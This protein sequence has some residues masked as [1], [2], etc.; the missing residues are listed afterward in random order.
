[1]RRVLGIALFVIGCTASAQIRLGMDVSKWALFSFAPEVG[2]RMGNYA[3][4]VSTNILYLDQTSDEANQS[5]TLLKMSG[6]SLGAFGL[7]YFSPGYFARADLS[8]GVTDLAYM[9]EDWFTS[10][11]QGITYLRYGEHPSQVSFDR[12]GMGVQVGT[13]WLKGR[14]RF[15]I[16]TG[17]LVRFNPNGNYDSIKF[18]NGFYSSLFKHSFGYGVSPTF[19][20]HVY[21]YLESPE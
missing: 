5:S 16:A 13:E 21:Y 19:S 18:P 7:Y 1:M 15:G 14:F 9:K 8:Y 11:S 4:G 3:L 10:T 17:F 2:Y 20:V 6:V 12:L